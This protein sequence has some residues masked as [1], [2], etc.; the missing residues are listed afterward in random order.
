MKPAPL[1]AL[2]LVSLACS[3]DPVP[4]LEAEKQQVLERTLPK[5]EFWGEV[6]RKGELLKEKKADDAELAALVAK[7]AAIQPEQQQLAAS[8]AQ[9]RDVNARAAALL[10]Q[11][12]AEVA[13]LEGEVA[14]R[15]GELAGFDQRRVAA[16]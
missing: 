4:K 5:T 2:A 6:G 16:P 9:A 13:R 10:A 3:E 11:D 1:L 12:R 15:L 14:K 7:A 8:L